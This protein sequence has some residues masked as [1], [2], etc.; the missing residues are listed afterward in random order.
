M[1]LRIDAIWAFI[2]SDEEGEGVCAFL[3]PDGVWLPLVCADET[4]VD[5][6]RQAAHEMGIASGKAIKLVKFSLREEIE[7]DV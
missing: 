4:R 7:A 3:T 6:L 2:S 5:S 1:P